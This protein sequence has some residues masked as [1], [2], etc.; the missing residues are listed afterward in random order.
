MTNNNQWSE[1]F[2]YFVLTGMVV[3]IILLGWYFRALLS[4]LLISALLAYILNPAV[5]FF[6]ERTRISHRGSVIIIYTISLLILAA[7]PVSITP[8]LV[9]QVQLLEIDLENL[10]NLYQEFINQ[11]FVLLGW[12]Y[13]PR[14]FLPDLTML[15][16][17]LLSP[18]AE[19]AFYVIEVATRNIVWLLVILVT[20]YYLLKDWTILRDFI[21]HIPPE[22]Y[23]KDVLHL[24][25]LLKQV[26]S[27]YL[28][29][30]LLFM[31]AVGVLDAI[32]WL[33]IGLPGA[34]ILGFLT[35]VLSLVPEFGAVVMG[36]LS[37]LVALI[38]GPIYLPLSNF[39]FAVLV[40]ILYLVLTNIK[41]IWLR[42][43]IVGRGVHI[44]EGIVFVVIIAA[45]ILQGYLA[46]FLSVP[47]LVSFLVIGRYLRRRI[48]GLPPFPEQD[49]FVSDT[50]SDN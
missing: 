17:D 34:L 22:E 28:R 12:T 6:S 45:L 36:I 2:R 19:S 50:N 43:I 40:L 29:S 47:I 11:P 27:D 25:N 15:P 4:P 33:I 48:L 38:E 5:N 1:S 31:I 21:F 8:V 13:I 20:T 14:Q 18:V 23:Q 9:S 7:I 16:T 35:G 37:L 39:W 42:P 46:A 32:A 30:Q 10:F 3:G 26:W 49:P 41:N 24:Y 44:H